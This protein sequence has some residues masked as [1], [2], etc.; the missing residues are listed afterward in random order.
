M[1]KGRDVARSNARTAMPA[2]ETTTLL[3]G[4]ERRRTRGT[5]HRD[6]LLETER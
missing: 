6:Q 1:G 3:L 5:L 4:E 2:S